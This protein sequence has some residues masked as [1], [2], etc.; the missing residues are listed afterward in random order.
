MKPCKVCGNKRFIYHDCF[1][2]LLTETSIPLDIKLSM[3]SLY[4]EKIS[5]IVSTRRELDGYKGKFDTLCMVF[6]KV[7][8]YE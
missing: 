1:L 2:L 3:K 4:D 6:E 5:E 8:D 7:L